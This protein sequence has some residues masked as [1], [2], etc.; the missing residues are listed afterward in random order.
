MSGYR[1][2][3]KEVVLQGEINRLVPQTLPVSPVDGQVLIDSADKKLKVWNATLDRWIILGDAINQVFDNSDNGFAATTTQAAI[4]ESKNT[5]PGKARASVTCTFNGTISNNNWL[6]YNEVLP[7][8]QVPI[9]IPFNC[10]LKEMSVI[11]S[12]AS[13]DGKLR[14][15]KNGTGYGNIVYTAQFT[16]DNDGGIFTP[17][18]VFSAGDQLRGR[19]VDEGSNPVDMAI[20]YFFLITD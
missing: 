8:N 5:A 14:L 15:Y 3:G 11:Y 17:N 18:V 1:L 7:G 16:D 19:W 2:K 12:N 4:E 13:I 9:L 6:G 10:I 20:V